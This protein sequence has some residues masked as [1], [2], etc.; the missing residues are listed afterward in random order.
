[1]KFV[2]IRTGSGVY[3]SLSERARRI[4]EIFDSEKQI[5]YFCCNRFERLRRRVSSVITP[6]LEICEILLPR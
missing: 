2:R 5:V 1:M 3:P 6:G 4:F